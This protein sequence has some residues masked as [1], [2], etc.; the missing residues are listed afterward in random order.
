MGDAESGQS[1]QSTASA[2]FFSRARQTIALAAFTAVLVLQIYVSISLPSTYP[3]G[4]NTDKFACTDDVRLGTSLHLNVCDKV[5]SLAS[6][7]AGGVN[8]TETEWTAL[9]RL[10]R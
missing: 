6:T 3:R 5:I 9:E 2:R 4:L 7:S 10:L 1:R 8:L